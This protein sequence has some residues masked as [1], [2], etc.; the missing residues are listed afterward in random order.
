[1]TNCRPKKNPLDDH[2]LQR[3]KR[4]KTHTKKIKDKKE[5]KIKMTKEKRKRRK[6]IKQILLGRK[7]R[8]EKNK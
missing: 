5:I 8:D 3:E 2:I 6:R 1:M 7:N 4:K